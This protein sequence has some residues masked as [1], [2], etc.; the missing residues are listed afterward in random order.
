MTQTEFIQELALMY[1]VQ[2]R[3]KDGSVNLDKLLFLL[4]RDLTMY[5]AMRRKLEY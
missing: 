3:L 5:E 4:R 1:G 2:A